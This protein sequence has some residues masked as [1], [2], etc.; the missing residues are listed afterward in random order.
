MS[1]A[2]PGVAVGETT[3][4][5]DDDEEPEAEEL[6]ASGDHM[7]ADAEKDAVDKTVAMDEV[8]TRRGPKKPKAKSKRRSRANKKERDRADEGKSRRFGAT[9]AGEDA[10]AGA[11]SAS[12]ASPPPPAA[13]PAPD[14][15]YDA[16]RRSTQ[17]SARAKKVA[18]M[19][20]FDINER[21]TVPNGSS[22]MVAILNTDVEAEETFLFK[23]GGA[24]YGYDQNPYRVVRF[25]NNT[26]FVLEPG[27]ISIYTGNSFVGEGLSEAV[28]TKTS[29]TIPFAVEP[30]IAVTAKYDHKGD[31]MRLVRIVRGVLEVESFARTETTWTARGPRKPSAWSVLVRHPK[32]GWNYELVTRPE[33][34]EDLPDGYLVRL[35]VAPN[36]TEGSLTIAEQTPSRTSISIWD[37]RSIKLL[38]E[39]LLATDVTPQMRKKLEPVV[40]LRQEIGR[41]DTQI[42]GM[43]RQQVE[44]DQR[45]NQTRANLKAIKK[46]GAASALRKKLSKRLEEFTVEGD[47][48]G[49][50]V[51]ELQSARLEKKIELE[52]VLQDLDV[53]APTAEK[54]K[55]KKK[56]APK[57]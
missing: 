47:T 38:Q 30:S 18:G 26:E 17:A 45:A 49:R 2:E 9:M 51:V 44:L 12:P 1:A 54:K 53:R 28:G 56:A 16:L 42:E 8:A 52:D 57:K 48:L 15:D 25:K 46:D 21:V 32:A 34:T 31:E 35:D 23:P 11:A 13:E 55:N 19:T 24:G 6:E 14:M 20:R 5:F 29:A 10:P 41:I 7:V 36:K 4:D 3:Y 43:K 37:G 27:P 33:G 50:K 22:T 40:K 39:L